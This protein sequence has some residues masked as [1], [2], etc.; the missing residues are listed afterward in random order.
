MR[1]FSEDS[2]FLCYFEVSIELMIEELNTLLEHETNSECNTTTEAVYI[3][4]EYTL[5]EA[6]NVVGFGKFQ[7]KLL[8]ITGF[9]WVV[10]A[11]EIMLLSFVTPAVQCEW[12]LTEFEKAMISMTV[13]VGMLFGSVV[14]GRISD[15]YGRRIVF[16][17]TLT[18]TFIAGVASS[19]STSFLMLAVLRGILGVGVSGANAAYILF[20]E[21]LPSKNRGFY[22]T[23][24]EVFW[25]AGS[26]VACVLAWATI[27]TLGW[28]WYLLFCSLPVGVLIATYPLLPESVRWLQI[29]SRIEECEKILAQIA[30]ENN[31]TL[32]K[33]T[34]KPLEQHRIEAAQ[35]EM[36]NPRDLFQPNMRKL[37]LLLS[38]IWF[39]TSMN[40]YG[41][42]FMG[43]Q[44]I[45]LEKTGKRCDYYPTPSTSGAISNTCLPLHSA[46]YIRVLISN[47][48]E[49]PGI[50]LTMLLIDRFGRKK[51][52][53]VEFLLVGMTFLSLLFCTG[54]ILETTLMFVSRALITGVFQVLYVYTPEVYP[55]T[56]RNTALGTCSSISRLGGMLSPLLADVVSNVSISLS[57]SLFGF[58]SFLAATASIY[59]PK[60]T[61]NVALSS[62]NNS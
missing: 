32:P 56:I 57:L 30:N 7:V 40:Y 21:Y 4:N 45:I 41:A 2:E 44:L 49:L 34:L 55:T 59:L 12:N 53:T 20:S 33:G 31:R 22:L 43:N 1:I 35:K 62:L 42:V 52:Q 23:L 36:G 14:S 51:S 37:T 11:I 18:I 5:E 47:S 25:A 28:R 61:A 27:P 48:G 8:F 38:F 16:L 58:A 60:E 50:L 15:K 24:I 19:F 3:E 10:D 6:I 13:F 9:C 46:D 17:A 26:M 39:I 29:S 54:P